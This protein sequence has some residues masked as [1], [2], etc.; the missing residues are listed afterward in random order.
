MA[1]AT[2]LK[3]GHHQAEQPL[4]HRLNRWAQP[5]IP[6]NKM[7]EQRLAH[8]T[9]VLKSNSVSAQPQLRP[10]QLNADSQQ[11]DLT[12]AKRVVL[13]AAF[14]AVKALRSY[15]GAGQS[16]LILLVQALTDAR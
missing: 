10:A 6:A 16:M 15:A 5:L 14:A 12:P 1:S 11:A 8:R 13:L 9:P 7:F 3:A 4:V 2:K